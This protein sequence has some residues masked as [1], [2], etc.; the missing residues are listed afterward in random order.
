[1]PHGVHA[2]Q[3]L[4][5][6]T[7]GGMNNTRSMPTTPATTPP[8]QTVP[9]MQPYSGNQPYEGK[10]NYYATT[11]SSQTGYA[12]QSGGRYEYKQEMGPPTAPNT[13][14]NDSSLNEHKSEFKTEFGG[15]HHSSESNEP[16]E[17]G[18]MPNGGYP[19][20][21]PEYGYSAPSGHSQLS[22]E[23]TS[24]HHNASGRGTPRTMQSGQ[25]SWG[26]EY[27]TPIQGNNGSM[28]SSH[29]DSRA[30][31]GAG[32]PPSAYQPSLKRRRDDDDQDARPVS[33]ETYQTGYDSKRQKMNDPSPFGMPLHAASMQAIKTGGPISSR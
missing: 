26:A 21:R 8:G 22:P 10:P 31:N 5:I 3:P 16:Q 25:S 33:R 28:Y 32:Y 14:N 2:S 11:P 24:P 27:R 7:A 29:G 23:M 15:P 12:Q 1:M 18:Y 17:N 20:S 4:S 19:P 30:P 9:Q 13:G 6:D